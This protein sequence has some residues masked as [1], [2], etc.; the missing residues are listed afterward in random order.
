MGRGRGVSY[1][2]GQSSLSYLF[3]GG[4]DEA[5]AAPAKPAAAA[6]APAPAPVPAAADGEKLKGIPAGVRGNQSQTNNYFRAQGQ[7]CGN[8]LTVS[9]SPATYS[10]SSPF[11]SALVTSLPS[12]ATACGTQDRPSTKVHA[13]PGGG[14]SLGYLF[15]G[16]PP[17]SK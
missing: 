4:G 7:N 10:S 8:F 6:P 15:G 16:G 11:V 13:A 9:Q 17:G 14:S 1:G 3:G 12:S 2:G 5:A